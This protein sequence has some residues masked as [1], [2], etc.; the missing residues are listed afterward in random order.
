MALSFVGFAE[1]S[2][3]NG[4]AVTVTLPGGVQEGDV[5]YACQAIGDLTDL[6]LAMTT[7]GYTDLATELFADDTNNVNLEAYRKIMG[8]TPD[9]TYQVGGGGGTDASVVSVCH[10][11]RG[12]DQLTPEDVAPEVATG[13]NAANPVPAAI[14]PVTTGAAVI[15]IGASSISDTAT[16]PPTGYTNEVEINAADTEPATVSMVSKEGLTGGVQEAPAAFTGFTTSTSEAWAAITIAVRPFVAI[17]PT[18]VMA[19]YRPY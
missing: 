2:A 3:T 14:T 16:T 15:L 1:N 17:I 10:V 7:G 11:W 9:S 6:A 12:A 5:V 18:I 4:G 19:P 8:S 13:I